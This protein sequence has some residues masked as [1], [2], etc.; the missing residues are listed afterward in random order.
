MRN[1]AQEFVNLYWKEI[2]TVWT[3]QSTLDHFLQWY[4][5]EQYPTPKQP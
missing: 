5:D 2:S 4:V 1:Y 3:I